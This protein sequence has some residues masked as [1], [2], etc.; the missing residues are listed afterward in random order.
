VDEERVLWGLDNIHGYL[1]GL[2]LWKN[3]VRFSPFF[4]YFCPKPKTKHV[5]KKRLWG[6]NNLFGQKT[7]VNV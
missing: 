2:L 7:I 5:E 1:G 3:F 6:A 4:F